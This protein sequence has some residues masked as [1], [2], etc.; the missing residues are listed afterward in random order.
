MKLI[1]FLKSRLITSRILIYDICI[2]SFIVHLRTSHPK[3]KISPID[4]F[5]SR[6]EAVCKDNV[7]TVFYT[8]APLA[9]V[10][11]PQSEG[12]SE[13]SDCHHRTSDD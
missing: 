12:V 4:H 10:V 5:A 3:E 2:F 8:F 13:D 9:E 1:F 6:L 11:W 7:V